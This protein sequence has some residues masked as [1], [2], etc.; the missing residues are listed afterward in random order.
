MRN[1]MYVLILVSVLILAGCAAQN[2]ASNGWSYLDHND[3]A[4]A[5]TEFEESLAVKELPGNLTGLMEAHLCLGN[6]DLAK[7][8]L[9]RIIDRF[10]N[11]RF[12]PHTV[13][14]WNNRFP[15][16]RVSLR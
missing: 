11:H 7:E 6:Y 13:E 10:P 3:C 9:L 5:K 16:D 2:H 15:N 14:N 8:Y 1:V 12:T 4:N